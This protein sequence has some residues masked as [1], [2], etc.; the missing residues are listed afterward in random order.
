MCGQGSRLL[1]LQIALIYAYKVIC[2][3]S[4]E[5]LKYGGQFRSK[6]VLISNLE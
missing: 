6:S 2:L 4:H 3:F 1:K 5:T